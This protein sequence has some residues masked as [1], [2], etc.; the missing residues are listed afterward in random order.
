MYIVQ[1][2]FLDHNNIFFVIITYKKNDIIIKKY[3]DHEITSL[4]A[5]MSY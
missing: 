4:Q 5:S 3:N 2:I 1:I